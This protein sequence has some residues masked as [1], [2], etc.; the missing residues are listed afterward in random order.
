M[1]IAI[2]LKIND[3]LV[4]AADSASTVTY[5]VPGQQTGNVINVYNNANKIFNL[6]KGLPIGAI[7]W[8]GGSIG[9]ASIE[10]IVKDLRDRFSGKG[11]VDWKLDPSTY[12]IREVADKFREFVF[13]ELYTAARAEEPEDGLQRAEIGFI[14]AG[15]SAHGYAAEEYSIN[16]RSNGTCD[17]P[18][19]LRPNGDVGVTWAGQPE[20]LNRLIAGYSS[21][22]PS[23][24]Q[25]SLGVPLEQI[26]EVMSRIHQ[27]SQASLIVAPMPL[28]DAVD[29]AEFLVETTIKF[30]RFSPGP[31]T[32][33]GPVEIAAISKHEG[34]R[35]I[36]RKH[37]FSYELNQTE[38]HNAHSCK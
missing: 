32:V 13:D 8:G 26:P 35:W 33:G 11:L 6:Y 20:A 12:T 22:L 16:I 25:N 38:T 14:V 21:T 27:S 7:T 34:F 30:T 19:P 9:K 37:Y 5:M 15:Y 36:R 23:I 31:S 1:T 10:T 28:Q 29:L 17:G 3:G 2:S 18:T 4:L 24:L